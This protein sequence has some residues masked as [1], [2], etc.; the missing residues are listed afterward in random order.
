MDPNP[1]VGSDQIGLEQ[2]FGRYSFNRDFITFGR[3][4]TSLGLMMM[5]HQVYTP[6]SYK[7]PVWMHQ[8]YNDQ[9]PTTVD[10]VLY[11]IYDG[12]WSNNF[13]R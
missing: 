13:N 9:P 1:A 4:L 8:G 12:Y 10:L 2:A 7:M 6:H 3:Q 5:K 11:W